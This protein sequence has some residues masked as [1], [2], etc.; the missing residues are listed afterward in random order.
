MTNP[1]F[2]LHHIDGIIEALKRPN[3]HSFMHIPVQSG[4]DKVLNAMRR[5]YTVAEFSYLADRLKASVPDMFLL[6]D[7]ICGF[8]AESPADWEETMELARKYKFH[9]M[10]IS[11]FYARPGTPAARLKALKS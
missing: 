10:H 2:I 8:P 4:S 6:T 1:P 3:V 9:G 11:Q 5:E 7:I